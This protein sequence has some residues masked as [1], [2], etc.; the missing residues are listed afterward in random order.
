MFNQAIVLGNL[1]RSPEGRKTQSGTA[2]CNLSVATSSGS[3]DDKKTEW[4]NVVCWAKSADFAVQNGKKGSKVLVVGEMR[5]RKWQDKDGNDRWTS[6]IHVGG[7]G[8]TF[9]VLDSRDGDSAQ[10]QQDQSS[11]DEAPPL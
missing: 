4:H 3:G 11:H 5:T 2:V 6:E 9:R 1:G 7:Y 10:G 8:S